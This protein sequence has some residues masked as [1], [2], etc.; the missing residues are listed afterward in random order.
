MA[1]PLSM[2]TNL[3]LKEAAAWIEAKPDE[4]KRAPCLLVTRRGRHVLGTE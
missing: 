3:V 2:P 1:L 4:R